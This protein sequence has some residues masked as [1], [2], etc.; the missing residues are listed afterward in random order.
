MAVLLGGAALAMYGATLSRQP[1]ADSLLFALAIESGVPGQLINLRH[2]LLHPLAWSFVELWRLLG[3]T[4]RAL[5][6]L[7]MLNALGGAAAVAL[8]QHLATRATGS[9]WIGSAV[10]AGFAVSGATWLLSTEAE[11]V[12]VPLALNL[13]LFDLIV[14]APPERWARPPFLFGVGMALGIAV[15][16]YLSLAAL[17]PVAALA[18]RPQRTPSWRVWLQRLSWLAGSAAVPLIVAG[19]LLAVSVS[20][21]GGPALS[22]LMGWIGYGSLG[23]FTLPHGAYGF[24][25]S[26]LLYPGLGMN[27]RTSAYLATAGR[28]E[29]ATF[30]GYYALAAALAIV[31]LWLAARR[32]TILLAAHRRTV[33]L[34]ALWALPQ[35]ALA[36]YWVPGDCSFWAPVL[37]AWWLLVALLLAIAA[38]QRRGLAAVAV[39]ALV[40]MLVNA[41]L[42][43]L[44]RHD[45]Q[46]NRDYWIA[47]GTAERTD[48]ADI[49]VTGADDIL[50]LYLSYFAR[51][52]VVTAGRDGTARAV[53]EAL[54]RAAARGGRVFVVGLPPPA[55]GDRFTVRAAGHAAGAPVWEVRAE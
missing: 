21:D 1:T 26:L 55:S 35:A 41:A 43:V 47:A 16:V 40:L 42:F 12:T 20:A 44:P 45:R 51:R 13:A 46:R 10:A 33:T 7:Q 2:P 31:P 54:T 9:A 39:L 18:A 19:A 36:F 48:P 38:H 15:L 11:F 53:D 5:L 28:L 23:W 52:T 50:S 49:V 30:A 25:R 27:D 29:R 4:G 17:L 22:T 6:P 8:L 24:T 34:L 37:T 32:R 14:R 3:W